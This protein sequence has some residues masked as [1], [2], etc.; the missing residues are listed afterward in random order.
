[1]DLSPEQDYSESPQ[2]VEGIIGS[3]GESPDTVVGDDKEPKIETN[4]TAP[5]SFLLPDGISITKGAATLAHI[6]S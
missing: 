2:L 3:G 5:S 1:M 4:K 6:K